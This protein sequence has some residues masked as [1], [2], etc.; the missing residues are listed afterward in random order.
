[1]TPSRR[2]ADG[3]CSAPANRLLF[4]T[5]SQYKF[6][7]AAEALASANA[8]VQLERRL[9]RITEIQSVDVVEVAVHKA[10]AARRRL[11]SKPLIVEDTGLEIAG[12]RGFPGALLKPLLATAGAAGLARLADDTPGR[13]CTLVTSLIYIDRSGELRTFTSTQHGT[14]A[15]RPCGTANADTWNELWRLYIPPDATVPWAL[16]DQASRAAAIEDLRAHSV[17]TRMAAHLTGSAL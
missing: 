17:Y 3:S 11:G 12:L 7:A 16:C 14:L 6:Q 1:M 5:S 4:P 13:A 9:L 15:R 10:K 2:I 8:D